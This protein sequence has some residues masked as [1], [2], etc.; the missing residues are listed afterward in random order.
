[1]VFSISSVKHMN[2]HNSQA[3]KMKVCFH[4][5]QKTKPRLKKK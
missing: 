5:P 1:M 3:G 4:R 2:L